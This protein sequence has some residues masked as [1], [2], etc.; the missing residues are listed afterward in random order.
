MSWRAVGQRRLVQRAGRRSS[1][2][3][4]CNKTNAM[5]FVYAYSQ[6]N[7]TREDVRHDRTLDWINQHFFTPRCRSSLVTI[8]FVF[9]LWKNGLSSPKTSRA[10]ED[11]KLSSLLCLTLFRFR[12]YTFYCSG[13]L[14][15][16]QYCFNVTFRLLL[17]VQVSSHQSIIRFA[18][19]NIDGV[20]KWQAAD[21]QTK[22]NEKPP[23]QHRYSTAYRPFVSRIVM[24][25][26]VNVIVSV[27]RLDIWLSCLIENVIDDVINSPVEN[28]R[29]W[30]LPS[31]AR[32]LH[33]EMIL[34][35]DS[36]SSLSK[37]LSRRSSS[38]ASRAHFS[39]NHQGES[40]SWVP[41]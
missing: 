5:I 26:R 15:V 6:T 36:A 13:R 12:R 17:F 33:Q 40:A 20:A 14:G 1:S 30:A 4:Y 25:L 10:N 29:W 2:L 24:S 32:F 19:K 8:I 37:R 21:V 23:A 7:G 34:T 18:I 16:A 9:L 39:L 11:K 22:I 35:T 31:I 27:V 28:R 38:P 41:K 3:R